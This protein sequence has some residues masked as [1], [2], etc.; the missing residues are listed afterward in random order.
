MIL[1]EATQSNKEWAEYYRDCS[2]C[3]Y[4]GVL[5]IQDKEYLCFNSNDV[6]LVADTTSIDGRY[7]LL[8]L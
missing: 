4:K 8:T 1:I 6:Q 2:Y 5:T 3:E 7:Y